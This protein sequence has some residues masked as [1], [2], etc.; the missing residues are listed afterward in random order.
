MCRG[1]CAIQRPIHFDEY[2]RQDRCLLWCTSGFVRRMVLR[3][4]P[5]CGPCRPGC[6]GHIVTGA[7]RTLFAREFTDQGSDL[8]LPDQCFGVRDDECGTGL[9]WSTN[10][11]R[12]YGRDRSYLKS[13]GSRV[14][15]K[16]GKDNLDFFRRDSRQTG[17][18]TATRGVV[19]RC[20]G[21]RHVMHV[22]MSIPCPGADWRTISELT[23]A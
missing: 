10:V 4:M 5:A 6:P 17:S 13:V 18:V 11:M 9:E 7:F 12:T 19:E 14:W 2:V 15:D 16:E 8:V 20:V 21:K 1:S 23:A 22:L 3:W